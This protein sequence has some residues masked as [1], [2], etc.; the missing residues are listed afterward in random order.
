MRDKYGVEQ[1]SYCYPDSTVLINL[2]NIQNESLLEEAEIEFSLARAA[3]YK[4]SFEQFDLTHLKN[5]HYQLFHDLYQWAG[6]IRHVDISKNE[7]RFCNID[8]IAHESS[9]LFH[10][11]ADENNLCRLE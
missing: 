10:A 3:E 2:L 6:K 9:K 7:T 5:I 1:D 4:P 8:R 11:L